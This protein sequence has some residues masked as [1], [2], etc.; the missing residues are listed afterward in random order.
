[1]FGAINESVLNNLEKIYLEEGDEI[2][3]KEFNKY[4]KTIKENKDLKEFYEVYDLFKQVNFDDESIAKEFVEESI[5]YLKSF[6]RTQITK[7]DYIG[8]S[9]STNNDVSVEYKL[10]QLIFNENINLKDKAT[11]KVKL[12]KQITKKDKEVIDYKSKFKVLHEKIN[13]NVSKLNE[14]ESKILELFVENDNEKINNFYLNLINETTEVVDNKIL[15][16]DDS[17]TIKKLVEVKQKLTK[18][19]NQTPTIQQIESIVTLKESF[20]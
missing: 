18:L 14:T 1:M 17:T 4:I 16:A 15:N 8:E 9:V 11:L 20:N 3:K 19:K 2:F 13:E 5:N 12:I 10:D 6:D 7:L